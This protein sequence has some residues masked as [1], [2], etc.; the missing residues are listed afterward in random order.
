M[1]YESP[2]PTTFLIFICF[3]LPAGE[4]LL[5]QR[6]APAPSE[7]TSPQVT[8]PPT[9]QNRYQQR[10]QACHPHAPSNSHSTCPRRQVKNYRRPDLIQFHPQVKSRVVRASD[11]NVWQGEQLSTGVLRT[12]VDASLVS[13]TGLQD[14]AEAWRALFDPQE[15]IAIKVNTFRNSLIWTHPALVQAVTDS[16]IAAGL[17]AE[18]II[19]YDYYTDELTTAGFTINTDGPGVRCYGTDQSDSTSWPILKREFKISDILVN[20]DALINMPVLKSHMISGLTFAL[21]NH[22][23]SVSY[24]DGLHD[25]RNYLPALSSLPCIQQAT[26][27][28]IGDALQPA[29]ATCPRSLTGRKT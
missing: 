19:L 23:G 17:T 4:L 25:I 8:E 18:N 9:F 22:Y 11:C 1:R 2:Q 13:L 21:K 15:I 16:M 12:M 3:F 24:P 5:A 10:T 6:T 20:A 29:R 26:R 27:L 7:T 14:A 28:V